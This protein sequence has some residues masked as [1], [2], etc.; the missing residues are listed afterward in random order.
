MSGVILA[1]VEHVESAPATLAAARTL[2]G[3]M[4]SARINVLAMRV[5]PEPRSCRP[6]KF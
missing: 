6:K 5:P 4:G 2:A 1:L 3:L